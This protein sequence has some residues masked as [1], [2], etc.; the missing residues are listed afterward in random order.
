MPVEV[1]ALLAMVASLCEVF[2]GNPALQ[3][4]FRPRLAPE[5]GADAPLCGAGRGFVNQA[6][7]VLTIMTKA[8]SGPVPASPPACRRRRFRPNREAPNRI[9]PG[10]RQPSGRRPK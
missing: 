2:C 4:L 10:L 9:V 8:P 5:Q 7:S 6:I 3:G 1:D